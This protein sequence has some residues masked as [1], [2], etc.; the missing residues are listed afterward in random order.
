MQQ[1]VELAKLANKIIVP[2]REGRGR[3]GHGRY[4]P[5]LLKRRHLR[6]KV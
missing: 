2:E 6:K 5:R 4:T 3:R 1:A